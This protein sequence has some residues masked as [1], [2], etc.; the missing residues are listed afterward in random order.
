MNQRKQR[1]E[2]KSEAGFCRH[3]KKQN[4]NPLEDLK[5]G[6]IWSEILKNNFELWGQWIISINVSE[7][8]TGPVPWAMMVAWTRVVEGEV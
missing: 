2:N 1:Q 4:K 7:K 5:Q 6:V 3:F 8:A